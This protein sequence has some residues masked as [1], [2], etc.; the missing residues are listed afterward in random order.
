MHPEEAD[1]DAVL[2]LEG[3][4]GAGPVR[5]VVQHLTRLHVPVVQKNM[6]K[7]KQYKKINFI[8]VLSNI[9]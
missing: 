1:V 8:N 6:K 2:L 7:L 9:F 5:E 3:E 4:H